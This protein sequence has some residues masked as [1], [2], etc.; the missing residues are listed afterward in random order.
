MA[1]IAE[2]SCCLD[3]VER[4][5]DTLEGSLLGSYLVDDLPATAPT[6]ARALVSD[7]D[8]PTFGGD[9]QGGGSTIASVVYTGTG[10][11]YG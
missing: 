10:W 2:L 8:T 4:R 1:T 9:P 11:I 7:A 3:K 6:G 5:V